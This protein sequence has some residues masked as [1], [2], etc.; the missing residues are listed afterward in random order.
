M[1]KE[2][3]SKRIDELIAEAADVKIDEIRGRGVI[4]GTASLL[5]TVYGSTSP[6]LVNF[7]ADLDHTR[8]KSP[9]H[10]VAYGLQCAGAVLKM[11]RQ[12]F[13]GGLLL[14]LER[15]LS[16]EI[17]SD[18]I[19]LARNAL[20]NKGDGAKNVAA[21]LTAAVYEDT[22]R[23]IA[24]ISGVPHIEKLADLLEELKT[25][26]IIIG[27]TV[28]VASSYLGFRNKALHADWENVNRP[29]IESALAFT[30]TMMLEHL[31]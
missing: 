22:M 6:Q 2:D 28:G 21:V 23:R 18:F 5:A 3:L 20:S 13:D 14:D 15:A 19:A 25:R 24:K 10:F 9:N 7:N 27:A 11:L 8:E 26:K 1:N 29:E 16:G 4:A 31:G 17:L 12:E 30:Q